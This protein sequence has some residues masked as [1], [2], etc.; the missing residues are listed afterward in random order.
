MYFTPIFTQ[1]YKV[2][3]I[4]PTLQRRKLRLR[5]VKY[6]AQCHTVLSV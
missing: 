6:L 1:T 3:I 2:D 5:E 4:I